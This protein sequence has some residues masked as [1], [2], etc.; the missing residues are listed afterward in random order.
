MTAPDSLAAVR[1]RHG[2]IDANLLFLLIA[3]GVKGE[4]VGRHRR[5]EKYVPEDLA[6]LRSIIGSFRA[7]VTTPHV[8]TEVSNLAGSF[9]GDLRA[10]I[11]S[12]IAGYS[13]LATEI[14][15]ESRVLTKREIF[16]RCGL[17]DAMLESADSAFVILTDDLPLAT[18]LE[19]NRRLVVNFN[20]YR[21]FGT[22]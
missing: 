13:H 9:W 11:F 19:S 17:A 21:R 20:H 6:V 3:G 15:S 12:A 14:F 1:G 10:A 2:I 8:L 4:L 5:L 7:H 18:F 22:I 16:L